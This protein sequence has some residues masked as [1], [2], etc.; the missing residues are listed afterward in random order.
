MEKVR[1]KDMDGRMW[2]DGR[3]WE[4]QHQTLFRIVHR[5]VILIGWGKK[6]M[7]IGI[8]END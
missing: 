2:M 3:R 5:C 7:C 8:L 1:W 4:E 6:V